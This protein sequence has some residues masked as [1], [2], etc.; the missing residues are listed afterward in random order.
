MNTLKFWVNGVEQT[1]EIEP[2]EMLADVLRY[3]LGLTG[4][5]IGCNEAE[6]G[7]CTV[8]LDGQA[9]LSCSYPAMRAAGKRVTTIEGL[10]QG[11]ELSLIHI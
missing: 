4:T 2:D 5:K 7:S 10:S 11:E 8:I 3:R 9:I 1:V 6:C